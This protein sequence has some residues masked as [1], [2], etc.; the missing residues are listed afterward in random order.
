MFNQK[1]A[2]RSDYEVRYVPRNIDYE[3]Q[4][5]TRGSRYGSSLVED[6]DVRYGPRKPYYTTALGDYISPVPTEDS[7]RSS[8][9]S[10]YRHNYMILPHIVVRHYYNYQ[11]Y[12]L[13][14]T[15]SSLKYIFKHIFY[16]E[17]SKKILCDAKF[18]NIYV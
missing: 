12:L 16:L 6:L 15:V 2:A 4:Y 1:R 5:D 17:K 13:K 11:N 8:V 3:L 14:L 10:L 7:T 9:A 18:D